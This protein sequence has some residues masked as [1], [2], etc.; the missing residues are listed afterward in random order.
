MNKNEMGVE[1]EELFGTWLYDNSNMQNSLSAPFYRS[2]DK[3]SPMGFA[4]R[5]G[6][7]DSQRFQIGQKVGQFLVGKRS[8]RRH[9]A[10][11]FS[12]LE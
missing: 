4:S 8:E 7:F 2:V 5:L 6:R 12:E 10:I 11:R 1:I 9:N 3:V